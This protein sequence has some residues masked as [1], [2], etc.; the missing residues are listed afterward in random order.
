MVLVLLGCL[1][2]CEMVRGDSGGVSLS[3]GLW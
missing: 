3:G 2:C 1:F